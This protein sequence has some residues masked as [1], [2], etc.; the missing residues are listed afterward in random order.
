MKKRKRAGPAAAVPAAQKPRKKS[1]ATKETTHREPATHGQLETSTQELLSLNAE[2]SKLNAQLQAKVN[3]LER[4]NNDLDNLL[5]S[6]NIATVILDRDAHIRR[7]TPAATRLFKLIA[8][9]VGRPLGNITPRFTDPD[10]LTDTARVLETLVPAQREVQAED[11]CWYIRQVLPYRSHTDRIEGTVITFSDGAAEVLHEERLA[12]KKSERDLEESGGR[13]RGIVET[14]A[15]GIITIDD[16]SLIQT[17]NPAAERIFGYAAAEILGRNVSTLIPTSYGEEHSRHLGRYLETGEAKV[18]GIGREVVGRRKDGSTFPMELAVSEFH[19][20]KGQRFTGIVRDITERKEAERGERQHQTELAHVLR[21]ST[22]GELAAGLA[23]EVSQPLAAIA[24]DLEACAT[25]VRA[26][27]G[28]APQLLELLQ[29]AGAQA[30]RAGEIVHRLR[31]LVQKKEPCLQVIDLCEVIRSVARYLEP[32]TGRDGIRMQL[33]LETEALRVRADRIQIEQAL[34]NL[35]HNGIDALHEAKTAQPEVRIRAARSGQ[36]MAQVAVQDNGP[37]LS[38]GMAERMFE[39][40][41]TS[42]PHG[43]GMGLAICRS[44]VEAHQGRLWVEPPSSQGTT[45]CFALPLAPSRVGRKM[46]RR[47]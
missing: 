28:G 46:K 17:F 36:G 6:T 38:A 47:T 2:L 12:R 35:I 27:K 7:F 42:K 29:H 18:I 34:I 44:I 11:G 24:N 3:E 40:L 30:L 39:P 4:T 1:P 37:G 32:E 9:D 5:T 20:G 22:A 15:D 43:L 25:H 21:L 14:A 10:L 19:D 41:F 31:D 13:L 8:S 45:V 23:H 16:E 33:D 26:G